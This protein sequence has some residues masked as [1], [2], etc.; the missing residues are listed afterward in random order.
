[1]LFN[2]TPDFNSKEINFVTLFLS[3]S[4]IRIFQ[5]FLYDGNS[6]FITLIIFNIF[7]CF[8]SKIALFPQIPEKL[9]IL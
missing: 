5:F 7:V 4:H 3:E 6:L 8:V 1:M 2:L 9:L